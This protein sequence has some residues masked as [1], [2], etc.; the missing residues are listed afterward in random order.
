MTE[1]THL[2]MNSNQIVELLS[3]TPN[4][5][6]VYASNNLPINIQLDKFGLIVNTDPLHK[7]G[8]HWQAIVVKN[9][10][11]YFFDSLG[12]EPKV[13]NIRKFCAQFSRCYF[14]K[15]KHQSVSEETCGAYCI[16]VINEMMT[17]RRS[18][19]HVVQV[20]KRIKRDDIF[21]RRYLSH[22]FN[23]HF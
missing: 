2:D 15:Q 12:G 18:F 13:D 23:F 11:C 4:F 20:F 1:F 5:V 17:K 10:I 21:V 8:S 3:N 16:F 6:G 7:E 22:N 9:K 14:N 19:G